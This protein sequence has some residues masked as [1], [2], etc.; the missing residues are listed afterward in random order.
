MKRS[1]QKYYAATFFLAQ[2]FNRFLIIDV[3]ARRAGAVP[4]LHSII[5]LWEA[6]NKGNG[7]IWISCSARQRILHTE[8]LRRFG[9]E[10]GSSDS[11]PGKW[12]LI[13]R[14]LTADGSQSKIITRVK[15]KRSAICHETDIGL[16]HTEPHFLNPHPLS[17]SISFKFAFCILCISSIHLP[18]EMEWHFWRQ[19]AM[20]WNV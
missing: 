3:R 8:T 12:L 17:F 5:Q 11:V 1:N 4:F 10:L 7:R 18:T 15:G 20:E 9:E 14:F 6:H 16:R 13:N 19:R 2:Y